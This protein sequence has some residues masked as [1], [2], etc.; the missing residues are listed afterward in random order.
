MRPG[1]RAFRLSGEVVP[2][3]HI[4]GG[5]ANS[6]MRRRFRNNTNFSNAVWGQLARLGDFSLIWIGSG[7]LTMQRLA[8]CSIS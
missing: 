6:R 1:T 7:S 2:A 3:G 5:V 4:T 8:S